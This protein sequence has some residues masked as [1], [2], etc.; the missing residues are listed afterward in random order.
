MLSQPLKSEFKYYRRREL[1]SARI[2]YEGVLESFFGCAL[3]NHKVDECPKMG[4]KIGIKV[5]KKSLGFMGEV[6]VF[7]KSA[8][9]NPS[10]GESEP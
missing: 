3:A 5:E 2:D 6:G 4:K 8:E 7:D 10:L 9:T 1:K